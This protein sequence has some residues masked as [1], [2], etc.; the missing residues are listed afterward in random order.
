MDNQP[1]AMQKGDVYSFGIILYELH[2]RNEPFGETELTYAE[3]L[4]RVIHTE[5]IPYR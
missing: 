1:D 5:S 3:I 2:T 4:H